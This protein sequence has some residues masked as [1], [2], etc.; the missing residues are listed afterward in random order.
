MVE[1]YNRDIHEVTQS[2][3]T[4]QVARHTSGRPMK[5]VI[6]KEIQRVVSA[7]EDERG[8]QTIWRRPLVGF[9]SAADPLFATLKS[10][11]SPTHAMPADL[12]DQAVTVVA[13]FL[14]FTKT[15][16][17]SNKEGDL[18]SKEWALAYL[19]TNQ[20]IHEISV[21]M[22]S[23]SRLWPMQMYAGQMYAAS[24]SSGFPAHSRTP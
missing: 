15:L 17:A 12:I 18:A 2:S 22:K 19:Q 5:E 4:H 13:F 23:D 1:Q 6:R 3:E 9:A 10:V 8:S 14:P 20:L 21:H 24:A 11:V 7:T 16:A